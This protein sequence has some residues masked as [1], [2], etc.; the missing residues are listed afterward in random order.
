MVIIL[1]LIFDDNNNHSIKCRF[2]LADK[3]DTPNDFLDWENDPMDVIV[4]PYFPNLLTKEHRIF[5]MIPN[6]KKFDMFSHVQANMD[7]DDQ[8]IKY[9]TLN[10]TTKDEMQK[11]FPNLSHLL[12]ERLQTTKNRTMVKLGLVYRVDI[13]NTG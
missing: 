2:A 11:L 12:L 7:F 5:M 10:V 13:F 3:C 6:K 8:E 1:E 9:T 4:E